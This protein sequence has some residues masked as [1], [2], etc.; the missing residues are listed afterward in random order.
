MAEKSTAAGPDLSQGLNLADIAEGATIS[1]RVKDEPVLLSR[2]GK[3]FFAVS[4]TCTHYGAA[5]SD[6]LASG[7][8]IRC[9]WHHACFSLRTGEVHRGP[10]L[11]PLQRW[12]VDIEGDRAFVREQL[13]EAPAAASAEGKWTR[14]SS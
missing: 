3:E 2:F 14:S 9:P 4:G 5:L 6:G 8:S 1:G 10:A 13:A 11:D 12:K 7:E